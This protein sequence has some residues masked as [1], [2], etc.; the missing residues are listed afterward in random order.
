MKP[1]IKLKKNDL[2]TVATIYRRYFR[3]KWYHSETPKPY[4]KESYYATK[5]KNPRYYQDQS[6]AQREA[7]KYNKHLYTYKKGLQDEFPDRLSWYFFIG[8]ELHNSLIWWHTNTNGNF[9]GS[10]WLYGHGFDNWSVKNL[11]RNKNDVEYQCV[12]YGHTTINFFNIL[13]STS[14]FNKYEL[15]TDKNGDYKIFVKK[16]V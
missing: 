5:V 10:P 4:Y 12:D 13:F 9:D 1:E 8:T 6:Q 2:S 11:L 14:E 15:A 16:E 3:G 7:D